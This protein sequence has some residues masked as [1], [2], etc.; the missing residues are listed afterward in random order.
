M[1]YKTSIELWNEESVK[2]SGH[3]S[4]ALYI[5]KQHSIDFAKWINDEGWR[6][7]DESDRWIQPHESH[8]VYTTE[9]LYN[10]FNKSDEP[11]TLNPLF[12]DIVNT[13]LN[14]NKP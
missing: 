9:Q 11:E 10:K 4:G 5:M 8:S 14:S 2:A 1:K 12:Q 7:Y 3:K 6:E 13:F